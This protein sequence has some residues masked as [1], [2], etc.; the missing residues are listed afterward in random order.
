MTWI[1]NM[2]NCP[3]SFNHPLVTFSSLTSA[4]L[5]E[6]G[7]S[8]ATKQSIWRRWFCMTSLQPETWTGIRVCKGSCVTVILGGL[9]SH[10]MIPKSS[11]YPPRPWVPKGSLKVRT[12]QATLVLF[13][14]GPNMRFPNLNTS[15]TGETSWRTMHLYYFPCKCVHGMLPE[16]HE[17]LYHLFAQVVIYTVDLVLLEQGRQMS[18][19]LL[20]ALEVTAKGLLNND[21]VPASVLQTQWIR[22]KQLNSKQII[23]FVDSWLYQTLTCGSCSGFWYLRW[24]RGT[25]WEAERGRRVCW[26]QLPPAEMTD[27][28]WVEW[29]SCHH[30]TC[31]WHRSSYWRRQRDTRSL[32]Q[33]PKENSGFWFLKTKT[34]SFND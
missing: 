32:Q 31:L 4:G 17:V 21:P 27:E 7:F 3:K 5:V 30:H 14:M 8:M 13:Q 20:W 26:R 16:H 33:L 23:C 29:K 1:E 25:Q 24:H 22:L 6:A 15:N 34:Q 28:H 9:V 19:Q 11:K 18:W 2:H 10:R 12:T